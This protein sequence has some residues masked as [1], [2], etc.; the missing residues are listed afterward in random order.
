MEPSPIAT[1]F[2]FID[3]VRGQP[4]YVPVEPAERH[5]SILGKICAE[6]QVRGDLVPDAILA[7]IALE[8]ACEIVTLDRDFA[9]FPSLRYKLLAS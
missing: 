2:E 3:E 9:R 7:A 6:S 1:V 5:L 8:N 4:S